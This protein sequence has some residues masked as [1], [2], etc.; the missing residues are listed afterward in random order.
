MQERA[1]LWK[2]SLCSLKEQQDEQTWSLVRAVAMGA[3]WQELWPQRNRI[4][5]EIVWVSGRGRCI[6]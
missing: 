6:P 3:A 5:A 1:A 4:V 2:V